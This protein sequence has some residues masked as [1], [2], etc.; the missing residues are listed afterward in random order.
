MA[1][2]G[3]ALLW[4]CGN[5]GNKTSD[6]QRDTNKIIQ[7][8]DGTISLKLDEA[9]CYNDEVDPSGNTAE[10][11]VVVS[12]SGRYNVWL[13][14]ATTDTTDLRYKHPVL[15]NIKDSRLEGNP[16]SGRII[17]NSTDVSYPYF[18][19]DS[20][21]GSMYIQDTGEVN[22]QVICDKIKPKEPNPGSTSYE[23]RSKLISVSLKPDT[24]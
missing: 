24:R 1:V 3:L 20:F 9:D 16:I 2:S 6:N 19:A 15:V 4:S 11:D 21:M 5:S 8:S 18:R 13:S 10:W 7:D 12:R 14:S 23:D 22:I 17:H